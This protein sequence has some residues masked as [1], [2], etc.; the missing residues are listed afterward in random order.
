MSA[1]DIIDALALRPRPPKGFTVEEWDNLMLRIFK[2]H[3]FSRLSPS[4]IT[5]WDVDKNL[6][7]VCGLLNIKC[8][9]DLVT[10]ILNEHLDDVYDGSNCPVTIKY[11][12]KTFTEF[13]E[14]CRNLQDAVMKGE[15]V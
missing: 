13:G 6:G 7:F 9:Y 1:E 3:V 14:L 5:R 11:L 2:S 15:I 8:D 4:N 10:K 12:G